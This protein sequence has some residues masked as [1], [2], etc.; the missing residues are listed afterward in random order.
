MRKR[1]LVLLMIITAFCLSAC[2]GGEKTEEGYKTITAEEAKERMDSGDDII[3]L[4]VRTEAEF[5]EKH[6]P[7]AIVIP[8]E[9][10]QDEKPARLPDTEAEILIY[11]R[12]GNRS[13]QAAKKLVAMGYTNIYDFGGIKDWKYET[14]SGAEEIKPENGEEVTLWVGTKNGGF[15][16]YPMYIEEE[17]SPEI[18]IEGISKL[19][20]WNLSLADEVTMGKGGMTVCFAKDSA[21]FVGPPEV[22]KEEFF[23]FDPAQLA[24]TIMDSIQKTLQMNYVMEPGNPD[25]LDIYFC[26]EGDEEI[27]IDGAGIMLPMDEPY[28]WENIESAA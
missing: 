8:N 13:A 5:E 16:E 20:G 27:V 25:T 2:S 11:C 17:L 22:Q 21:I 15:T 6:I 10:I 4:D 26:A 7:G 1:I 12:S 23:V 14:V 28:S 9:E 19:T 18:L 3:I 24:E